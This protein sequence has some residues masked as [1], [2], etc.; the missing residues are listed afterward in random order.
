MVDNR[1]YTRRFELAAVLSTLYSSVV[2][3]V[4]LA[5]TRGPEVTVVA[6]LHLSQSDISIYPHRYILC[7]CNKY[8]TAAT[9]RT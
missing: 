9:S 4:S 5:D 6:P 3:P 8:L 1:R 7:V 2:T